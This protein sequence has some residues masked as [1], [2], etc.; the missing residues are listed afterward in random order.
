MGMS[1]SGVHGVLTA[2][3]GKYGARLPFALPALVR[4]QAITVSSSSRGPHVLS[5]CA[6]EHTSSWARAVF[7]AAL[8]S[9]LEGHI[10]VDLICPDGDVTGFLFKTR[11]GKS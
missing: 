7:P 3:R 8:Q 6:Q 2:F 11:P 5:S 10:L 9:L 1:F 4:G